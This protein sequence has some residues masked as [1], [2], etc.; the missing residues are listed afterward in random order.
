MSKYGQK[1][2]DDH[3]PIKHH[4]KNDHIIIGLK[5]K[6]KFHKKSLTKVD[7]YY[8]KTQKAIEVVT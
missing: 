3:Q 4:E 2:L 5:L 7:L 1:D 8:I 6:K